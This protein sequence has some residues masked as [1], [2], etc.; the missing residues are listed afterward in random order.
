MVAL[1]DVNVLIAL[2]DPS[3]VHHEA[4]HGWFG[5]NRKSGWATCAL[6]E[7]AFARVLSNPAYPG[8]R[9]TVQDAAARLGTL[10]SDRQHVFWN[11]SV[12][13]REEGR[14]GWSHVQGH[15]QL[16]DVY[17]LALAVAKQARLATFDSTISLRAVDRAEPKNLELIAV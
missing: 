8:S 3:H 10:C 15:R 11:D 17:L 14:F 2:F 1:L 7:N 4:A 5:K 13:I 16:T 6:T 12:S 9:T